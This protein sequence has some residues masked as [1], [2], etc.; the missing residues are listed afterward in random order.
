[1]ASTIFG[2]LV[3]FALVIYALSV[4]VVGILSYVRRLGKWLEEAV[5]PERHQKEEALTRAQ[6]R[7]R[8]LAQ[9]K[10]HKKIFR[11]FCKEVRRWRECKH[12][13][14]EKYGTVFAALL[15]TPWFFRI[16][17]VFHFLLTWWVSAMLRVNTTQILK[18][19]WASLHWKRNVSIT[20]ARRSRSSSTIRKE[21]G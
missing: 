7:K 17:L 12:A 15:C 21:A 4:F 9:R 8:S 5:F 19:K 11:R 14:S 6:K 18:E 13:L 10:A 2:L 16:L 1:M 3:W 20:E